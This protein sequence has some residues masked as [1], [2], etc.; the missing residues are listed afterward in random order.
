MWKS[1]Q[2]SEGGGTVVANICL[3]KEE[4]DKHSNKQHLLT[5]ANCMTH[6]QPGSEWKGL[7]LHVLCSL[8]F[9]VALS[10]LPFEP[11]PTRQSTDSPLQL[12]LFF[13]PLCSVPPEHGAESSDISAML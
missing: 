6:L 12:G 11:M 4:Q 8:L 10:L 13:T 3:R 1:K 2:C 5:K 7:L 9:K